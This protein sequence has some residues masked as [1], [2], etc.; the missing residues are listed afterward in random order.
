MGKSRLMSDLV[1]EAHAAGLAATW[2]DNVSYGSREPYRFGRA[3]AQAVAD[4]HGT[5]SG[6]MTRRLLF[7][8][9]V[10]SE[11]AMRWAGAIA[12]IAPRR[13]VLG[14]GR[15]GPARPGPI[16][17]RSPTRSTTLPASMR[18]ASSRSP[19]RG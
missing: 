6:S 16:R 1:D 15:G 8:S 17:P 14:L 11:R 5:D 18:P 12:A 13:G 19:A 7:T 2:V 9:D 4:E 3:F 10:R